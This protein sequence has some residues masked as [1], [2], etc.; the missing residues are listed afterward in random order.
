M[1]NG[2]VRNGHCV[3]WFSDRDIAKA[4]SIFPSKK[5]GGRACNK[6]LI[7]VCKNLRPDIVVLAH[8][9]VISNSTLAEIRS[10]FGSLI[11]QYNFDPFHEHNCSI[12]RNRNGFIDWN[13]ITTGGSFLEGLSEKGTKYAFMP[14]PVDRSID[15]LQNYRHSCLPIGAV[16]VGQTSNFVDNADLRTMVPKLAKDLQDTTKVALYNGIWGQSYFDILQQVKIGLNLSIFVGPEKSYNG[17]GSSH[18]LYSSDRIGQYLGNGLMT[19]V[20]KKFCLSE[21]YGPD[22]LVEVEDFAEL[23]D[24]IRHY[25]CNDDARMK[26][27][28]SSYSIAHDEFNER[29]VAQYI[30]EVATCSQLSHRYRWPTDVW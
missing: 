11:I 5:M 18:Y 7:E 24:V 6:K 2:F 28:H 21:L 14:N 20:E 12:L 15:C 4:S 25:S 16:F 13:F 19:V 1:N 9:D 17:N 30:V 26:K 3:Y 23:K 8:A 29:L 10:R 22:S 27:A